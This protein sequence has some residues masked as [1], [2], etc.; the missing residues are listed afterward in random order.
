VALSCPAAPGL[1]GLGR[2]LEEMLD[3][4][5]RRGTP[6]HLTSER[7]VSPGVLASAAG[8]VS[9]SG[10]MLAASRRFDRVA[11]RRLGAADAVVA[12]NGTA[13]AQFEAAPTGASLELMSAN[14]HY[15]NVIARH[16]L[17]HRQYPVEAPW[18]KR[19]LARNLAE[20][21]RAS[22]ILVTS[23]YMRDSFLEHGTPEER[24]ERFPLTPNPRF[25]PGATPG[26]VGA[27]A[28][29]FEIVYV[30]SLLV[31][32]GV[33][34]L[35]DAFSRLQEP[36]LRLRLIGGWTT[37]AMRRQIEAAVARDPR[38]SAG[39]GDPLPHLRGAALCVHPAYEEGFGYAPAEALAAGVPVLVSEDTGMK[40]L[41]EPGRTGLVVGTGD[42]VA[43]A[44]AIAAVFRGE[45]LAHA[46]PEQ[47]GSGHD[48]LD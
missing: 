42:A 48:R 32:K 38:I 18:A 10:R 34:L 25:A 9:P 23:D 27:R 31:H 19:L 22:K 4:F 33:P 5:S 41:I 17:A 29:R 44:E 16:E 14:S 6:V 8:R 15:R 7:D 39:P 30:G 35:L 26:T 1:G 36:E 43:L 12:F 21:R 11:A 45:E 2:H 24:L 28:G 46:A 13:L 40:E 3:A 37:R 20:Y 47:A